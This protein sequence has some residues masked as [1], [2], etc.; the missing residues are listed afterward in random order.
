MTFCHHYR[1]GGLAALAWLVLLTAGCGTTG[2]QAGRAVRPR[3]TAAA[4][5]PLHLDVAAEKRAAALA[6]Y[7]TALIRAAN[8]GAQAALPEYQ[9][10]FDLDPSHTPLALLLA[11]LYRARRDMTNALAV[12]NTAIA[13][14]PK[15]AEPWVAKGLTLRAQDD[16]TNAAAAFQR[17]V[18][19][20]PDHFGATRALTETLLAQNDTNQLVGFLD[21]QFRRPSKDAGY[22]MSLGD[23]HHFVLRQRPSL[24]ARLDRHRSR[25][26]Y[27]R[28]RILRPND[29]DILVRLGDACLDANDF[30]AAA[31]AYSQL[32][33][34]RPNLP[35]LRERL[36]AIYLKTEQHE[37][38][39]A[40][41]K[42]FIKRDPN[43]FEYYNVLG[44]LHEE[45]NQPD[46]ALNYFEQSLTL[47][48]NQPA[49]Y[50]AIAELHLRAKRHDAALQTLDTW[51]RKF[52]A[53]WRA[54]YF[55][56]LVASDR[57]DYPASLAGFTEAEKLIRES[58]DPV[59][60]GPH[61]HFS[62]GAAA[63]RTGDHTL[64]A[65]H[66]QRALT[67]KPDFALAHNY[68]GYM[69]ADAGTNLTTA[70]EHIQKAVELDPDNGA[71][72]DSL[73][74]V[75]HKL[76]RDSEALPHLRR[77][78]ELLEKD[79]ERAPEDRLEDVVVYDHLAIVLLKL[80]HRDE[81]IQTWK[82]ALEL[83]PHNK[84]IAEKLAR[85]TAVTP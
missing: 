58:P 59:E 18:Q 4:P 54:P 47:N 49:T 83:D 14:N 30:A 8:E 12:L 10:A 20:Q 37:K 78:I 77:A 1:R 60:P 3:E 27:E 67:L 17:A 69:W 65:R 76:G 24:A 31:E 5:V 46:T 55:R 29:P 21:Q 85:E 19:L 71:F 80:G 7:G 2:P 70:L 9:R 34:I 22:W 25:Q 13:A 28:A 32:V 36:A 50:L 61:F 40:L 79:T 81:A 82:R 51:Q 73:G 62:F 66:F 68:L 53:D 63:E 39:I 43:R 56:A 84:D 48:P 52:P 45:I 15:S 33:E 42:E 74:W 11:E 41:Y 44:E 75:L 38:A 64:A 6:H 16:L 26:C 35:Q 57:R 23:L 72:L